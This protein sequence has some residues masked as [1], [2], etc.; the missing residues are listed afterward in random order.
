ML[1]TQIY[2]YIYIHIRYVTILM[3]SAGPSQELGLE[4]G[5]HGTT[6]RRMFDEISYK[7]DYNGIMLYCI[8]HTQNS[9]VTI[10]Y[11]FTVDYNMVYC[12]T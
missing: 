11:I 12:N 3:D 5:Y 2:V 8:F 10:L 6:L 4:Y 7:W 1:H 9:I